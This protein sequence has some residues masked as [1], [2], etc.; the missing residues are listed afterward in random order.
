MKPTQE[1]CAQLKSGNEELV[2][3]TVFYENKIRQSLVFK[4]KL[5]ID[6]FEVEISP[7]WLRKVASELEEM[8]INQLVPEPLESSK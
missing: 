4:S 6:V 2:L 7:E 8:Q 3:R 5:N 1:H